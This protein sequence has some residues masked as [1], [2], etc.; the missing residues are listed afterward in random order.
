MSAL[1]LDQAIKKRRKLGLGDTMGSS[2]GQAERAI[3]PG[4]WS[5]TD[6]ATSTAPSDQIGN[7]P[8]PEEEKPFH[9]IVHDFEETIQQDEERQAEEAS[10]ADAVTEIFPNNVS[11]RARTL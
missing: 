6:D 3:E 4:G 9:T 1:S 11:G 8:M 2:T 5:G 7:P 10:A